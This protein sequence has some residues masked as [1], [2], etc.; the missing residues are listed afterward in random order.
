M[1]S[2]LLKLKMARLS[3][4]FV[5]GC[6]LVVA[7]GIVL[8]QEFGGISVPIPVELD[9]QPT[10]CRLY[11]KLETK[12]YNLPFEKFA[13]GPMDNAQTM[14]ATAVDA[15][16]KDDAAK[17]ASVWTSPDQMKRLSQVTVTL[18]DN[19]TD[20]WIKV[21]RSNFDFDKLTVVAEVLVGSETMF[22]WDAPTRAGIQR[23]AFYIGLDQKNQLRLSAVSSNSPVEPLILNAFVA[24]RTDPAVYKP[25][26]NI[27]VDY[28]YPIPLAGPGDAGAHPAFFEF[29]GAPMDFPIGDEKIKAPTP[30]LE[31]LRN[32]AFAI[33]SGKDKSF[34]S[35]FTPRSRETI[36]QWLAA[37]EKREQAKQRSRASASPASN[38][39]TAGLI[40]AMMANVKF[41][42]NAD[43]IF[44]VFQA[45]GSGDKWMPQA[46]S[47][48]YV[49]R[50]GGTYKIANFSSM[51]TLDDFLQN[52]A[53]F[54]KNILKQA[55][56][57]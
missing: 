3:A 29:D 12:S 57:K 45:R 48:S 38:Y 40:S 15:I 32:A 36:G 55:L 19:S 50:E 42:L 26:S 41:V 8:G 1:L 23:N 39:E 9:G 37:T 49:L 25:I 35:D 7:P 54:D 22:I 10:H 16:R 27:N 51:N 14:F 46:L 47:Y 52:P 33:R 31:F 28:Q 56:K 17:F 20:S 24:A 44:L 18:A 6:L 13:A 30:L 2:V 11:L 53:L 5:A 43:P 34:A 21:A 4:G